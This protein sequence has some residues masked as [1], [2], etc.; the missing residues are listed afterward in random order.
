MNGHYTSSVRQ[1]FNH[2]Y[3]DRVTH[4]VSYFEPLYMVLRIMDLEVVPTMPFVYELM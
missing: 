4:V 2:Q 1:T 3:W